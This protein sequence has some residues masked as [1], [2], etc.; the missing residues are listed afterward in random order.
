MASLDF[1]LNIITLN[2]DYLSLV[3][4]S[5][6]P[7]NDGPGEDDE[8]QHEEEEFLFNACSSSP[9]MNGAECT[10]KFFNFECQ[11]QPGYQGKQRSYAISF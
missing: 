7:Q 11:C 1:R 10:P 3:I 8:Q 4:Q 9:C 5:D 2:L 6:S